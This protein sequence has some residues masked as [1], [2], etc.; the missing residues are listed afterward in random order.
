MALTTL[1]RSDHL[2]PSPRL[3][4]RDW[5]CNYSRELRTVEW[6]SGVSLHGS[7]PEPPM[8]AL[9]HKR[10]FWPFIAMST[11]PSKADID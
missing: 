3:K 1:I 9:G 7:N 11:L 5:D 2:L 8:S 4:L 10:T 6:G